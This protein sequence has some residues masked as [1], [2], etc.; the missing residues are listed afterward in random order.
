MEPLVLRAERLPWDSSLEAEGVTS[1]RIGMIRGER[2][3]LVL[4]RQVIRRVEADA[5]LHQIRI[6]T[7]EIMQRARE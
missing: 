4:R 7:P 3:S 2:I 6:I 1:S 5:T